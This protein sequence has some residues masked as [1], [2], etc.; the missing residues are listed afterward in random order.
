MQK[1]DSY[2]IN[3]IGLPSI[4]LMERAALAMVDIMEQEQLDLSKTLV[5]CGSGNNGGDG[6]AIARLLKN[7]GYDTK[8]VFVGREASMS[9]D[10][11]RQRQIAENSGVLVVTTVD[12]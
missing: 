8:A 1:A 3:E 6:F 12:Q 4:V 2:T 11:K 5:F 10:C 9:E 7:R